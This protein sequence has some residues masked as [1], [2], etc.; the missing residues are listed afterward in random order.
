MTW[1]DKSAYVQD[2]E[3]RTADRDYEAAEIRLETAKAGLARARAR[4]AVA[5]VD[6][7]FDGPPGAV[8]GR[9][10][11]VENAEGRSISLGEWIERPDGYW[12]LRIPTIVRADGPPIDEDGR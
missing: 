11:E 5:L 10:V 3:T 12:V 4:A 6:I 1:D 2:M 8:P 7:V 9:F